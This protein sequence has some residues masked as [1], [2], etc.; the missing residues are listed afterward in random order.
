MATIRIKTGPNKGKNYDIQD[1]PLTVGR[2]DNQII[3]I[4]D[5]GVS[6]AHAEIFRLG[7]MCFIR[8][9][10][11][12]NGTFVNDVK[13]TEESLK[14]GDE[15]LIGTTILIFEDHVP[16][17]GSGEGVEFEGDDNARIESTTVELK[18]DT[19][20]TRAIG[21]EVQSRNLTLISQAGR[22]LRGERDLSA[23]QEKT[24]EILS[25]AI[26]ANQGF[27][28]SI[29]PSTEKIVPRIVIENEDSGPDRKVSR[30]IIN[31]VKTS[32]LPLLTT[33]A[34]LDERFSLSES[35]ILRKIKSVI[36]AP[37]HVGERVDSLLYFHSS[38]V[39]HAWTTE[40]LELVAS[41]ALQLSM[42][43]ASNAQ[44]ERTRQRLTG[45]LRAVATALE[46]G[47]RRGQGHAQ[48]VADYC[49]VI[50]SQMNLG[51]DDLRRVR[52]AALLH[53]V[54]KIAVTLAN[55]AATPEEIRD[56][57]V[58]AAEKMLTGIEG[59]EQ[60]LAAVRCHHERADGSGFPNKLKNADMPVIGRILI[61]ANA[62]DDLCTREG[63]ASPPA[64]DVLKELAQKGGTE[65]DDEVI[66]ALVLCH[67]NGT[68][69]GAAARPFE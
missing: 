13:I 57:H 48:R 41:V 40:D 14:A 34:T 4:L 21:K 24:V 67:R 7:E 37:V 33:D 3:Q 66:K 35:V 23:A 63:T 36:C 61:V 25:A 68:L 27:F 11:S 53:D 43:M 10:N 54:G 15:M 64:K 62:F 22:I 16:V 56:Q 26:G 19:K 65:F 1:T 38:K 60:V 2:E 18:V 44:A 5:Q 52:L 51:I 29:E 28:F 39:D 55:P 50:A 8:D 46:Y 45:A 69:Y 32:G 49:A 17:R 47:D 59:F 9:L 30:T 31:R 12:T 6:R 20:G 42:A 58:P